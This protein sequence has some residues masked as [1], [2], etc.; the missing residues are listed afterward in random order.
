MA[1]IITEQFRINSRKRLID[2]IFDNA[3]NYYISIGK[4][5]QWS[6]LNPDSIQTSPFPAGTLGDV[7]EVRNNISAMF[8]L[9]SSNTTTVIP[10]HTIQS[11]RSYKVYN[12]Y[13]P[14]CF[15]A[16]SEEY[17][18]FVLSRVDVPGGGTGSHVY[19]CIAKESDAA[20]ASQ[21]FDKLGSTVLATDAPGIYNGYGDGYNWLY[22][23]SITLNSNVN[24]G[25]FVAYNFNQDV[26]GTDD[27]PSAGLLHGFHIVNGGTGIAN[28]VDESVVINIIGERV[29][30]PLNPYEGG[31]QGL[32]TVTDGKVTKVTL[33][34]LSPD[35]LDPL[36]GLEDLTGFSR[37]SA[38]ITALGYEDVQIVPIVAPLSGYEAILESVLPS[39][40][41]GVSADTVNADYVPAGTS[42]RQIALIKNPLDSN[43]VAIT[44]S[45]FD[46]PHISFSNGSGTRLSSSGFN[47][48]AGWKVKQPSLFSSY[49]VATV[50]SV[51]LVSGEWR[52]YYYNSI[53]GGLLPINPLLNLILSPPDGVVAPDIVINTGDYIIDGFPEWYEPKSGEVL[54]IDNRGPVTRELGQNEE[55][56]IIIQL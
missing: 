23:G 32:V 28:V 8:K 52:Y 12:P 38:R 40:Y 11:D 37:L 39:W 26:L 35:G 44:S 3:N 5:N 24:N 17:P 27:S 29:D 16:N 2:D 41:V 31:I 55:I 49:D 25:A 36:I 53:S 51:E 42:Y 9:D 43:D 54:F 4:E 21:S 7:Q 18:C 13:D 1:A 20:T 46:R 47:V 45:V 33:D 19:L 15:Y 56:K 6:E 34:L 10:K 22:L 30:S 50:S 48:D 14:T